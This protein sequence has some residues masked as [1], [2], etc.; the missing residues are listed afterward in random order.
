MHIILISNEPN[1]TQKNFTR[2]IWLI[3]VLPEQTKSWFKTSVF[4]SVVEPFSSVVWINKFKSWCRTRLGLN[5]FV[6][7]VAFN[8]IW[9]HMCHGQNLGSLCPVLRGSSI[10]EQELWEKHVVRIP[11]MGWMT[12]AHVLYQ[13]WPRHTWIYVNWTYCLHQR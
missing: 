12:I 11:I 2:E 13:F 3:Y 4:F 8:S 10:H 9:F 5:G 1:E 7:F 6:V